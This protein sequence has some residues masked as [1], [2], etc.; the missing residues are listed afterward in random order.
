MVHNYVQQANELEAKLAN[1]FLSQILFFLMNVFNKNIFV[2]DMR[3]RRGNIFNLIY[4]VQFL[5]GEER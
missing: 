2:G 4:F 1:Y 5:K 3:G